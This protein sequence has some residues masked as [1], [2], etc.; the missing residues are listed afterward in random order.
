MKLRTKFIALLFLIITSMWLLP[1][2]VF[3]D[4]DFRLTRNAI[5]KELGPM[6]IKTEVQVQIGSGL[7]SLGK[8]AASCAEVEEEALKYL[9]DIHNVQVGVYKLHHVDRAMPLVIP[10]N[11][12]K[13]L[14]KKG[15]EPMVRVKE[16][17]E[18]VWVMTKMKGKRLNSLYVISLNHEE[19]VL[20]EVMGRLERLIEKAIQDQGLNKGEFTNI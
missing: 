8:L 10:Q 12:A 14:E 2:C 15:Y 7:I 9:K 13:Q 16:R 17:D 5:L 11:I 19:L 6:D 1:G 3:V 4:R 20:V 18:S